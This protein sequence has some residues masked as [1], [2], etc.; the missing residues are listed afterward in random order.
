M[1][2]RAI[3][4]EFLTTFSI[5]KYIAIFLKKSKYILKSFCEKKTLYISY[6]NILFDYN[7]N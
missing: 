2:N 5:L 7:P 4:H 3:Q 6:F 1:V